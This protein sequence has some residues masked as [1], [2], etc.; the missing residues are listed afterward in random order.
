MG[1]HAI[2]AARFVLG[3][4]APRSVFARMGSYYGGYDVDDTGLIVINWANDVFSTV[5]FGWRQPHSEGI[6]GSTH[7]YGRGGYA[8]LFPTRL[9]RTD[10]QRDQ[11]EPLPAAN[12]AGL[13][14]VFAEMYRA[15]LQH[16]LNCIESASQPMPGAREGYVI[17]RIV[18]AAYESSR[19]GQVVVLGEEL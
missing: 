8:R 13:E 14:A 7:F 3:D 5:E 6:V 2:D 19:S 11:T 18:D 15:Q 17:M 9:T 4:P 16:F 10:K 12:I 1:V